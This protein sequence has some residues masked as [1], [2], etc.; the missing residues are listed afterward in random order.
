MGCGNITNSH[1]QHA[2]GVCISWT[3][4]TVL[5]KVNEPKIC[6]LCKSGNCQFKHF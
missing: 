4:E 3:L 2:C 1:K 6:K 5:N